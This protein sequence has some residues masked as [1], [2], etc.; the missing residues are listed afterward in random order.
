MTSKNHSE[1]KPVH[2]VQAFA[3]RSVKQTACIPI[4]YTLPAE[5]FVRLYQIIGCPRRVIPPSSLNHD[6]G[7]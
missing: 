4:A 3:Y 6:Q 2:S 1:L 7:F 5:G